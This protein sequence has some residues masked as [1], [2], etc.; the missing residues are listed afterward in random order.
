MHAYESFSLESLDLNF[1]PE[2]V[3]ERAGCIH[4]IPEMLSRGQSKLPNKLEFCTGRKRN[5][6]LVKTQSSLPESV[7]YK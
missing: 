4:A 2:R 1:V 3:N 5:E 7:S 6:T